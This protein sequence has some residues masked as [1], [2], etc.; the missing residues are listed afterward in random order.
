M[1]KEQGN[2]RAMLILNGLMPGAEIPPMNTEGEVV[3]DGLT[4]RAEIPP[5][6]P[7]QPQQPAPEGKAGGD[8]K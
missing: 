1:P 4:P 7:P 5:A 3:S 6:P 8:K 2:D